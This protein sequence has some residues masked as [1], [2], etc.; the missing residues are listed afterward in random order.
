MVEEAREA[1]GSFFL[2]APFG[3][4]KVDVKPYPHYISI[5]HVILQM[6]LGN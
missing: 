6:E 4:Q 3:H 1:F 2:K 5:I